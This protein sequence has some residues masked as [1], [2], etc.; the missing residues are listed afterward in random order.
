[1]SSPLPL[2]TLV[3]LR[4]ATDLTKSI[5]RRLFVDLDDVDR[6]TRKGGQT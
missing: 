5:K 3:S 1:M 4:A 6:A 2:G